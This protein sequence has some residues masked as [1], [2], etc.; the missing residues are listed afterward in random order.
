MLRADVAELWEPGPDGL[1]LAA[2]TEEGRSASGAGDRHAGHRKRP[3]RGARMAAPVAGRCS[4]SPFSAGAAPSPR[5][6]SAGA[7]PSARWTRQASPSLSLLAAQAALAIERADLALEL[8]RQAETDPLTGVA[9]RRGLARALGRDLAAARRSERRVAVAV[10][11]LDH[12]KTYNDA[13][14]HQAGDLLLRAAARGWRVPASRRP[15]GPLRR[16]GVRRRAARG[17]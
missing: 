11:D 2:S 9:N 16:R 10:L 8:A 1:V 3:R 6:W 7:V 12:F 5:C 4:S 14:G 17:R 15:A 13:K